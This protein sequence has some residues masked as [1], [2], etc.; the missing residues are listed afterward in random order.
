MKKVLFFIIISS[1]MISCKCKK[2]AVKNAQ[3]HQTTSINDCF[4]NSKCTQEIFK[5][6]QLVIE[7]DGIGKPFYKIETQKGTTVFRYLMK[8]NEDEQYVDGGYR[9]EIIFELPS[10][11]KVGTYTDKQI[12]ETKALFGVFCFCKD[13][14]GYY[15]IK[16]GTITKTEKV[17]IV[18]FPTI[19]EDQVVKSIQIS[20]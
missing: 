11:L 8:Q 1:F 3:K 13:K 2:E 19:V 16:T 7:R 17:I 18:Q 9:E 4:E 12:L 20:L 6:S 10:D 15:P 14:A 5:D